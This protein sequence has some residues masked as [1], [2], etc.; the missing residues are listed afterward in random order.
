MTVFF[1]GAAFL[2][3]ALICNFVANTIFIYYIMCSVMMLCAI[4]AKCLFLSF[5][6]EK[7]P[8]KNLRENLSK[9]ISL[10]PLLLCSLCFERVVLFQLLFLLRLNARS[11][12]NQTRIPHHSKQSKSIQNQLCVRV[13]IHTFLQIVL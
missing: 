6:A 1:A 5:E 3:T 4:M 13:D 11:V 10:L 7:F 9:S 12:E 2:K 8:F